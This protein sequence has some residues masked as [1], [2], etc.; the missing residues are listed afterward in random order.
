MQATCAR[1][2]RRRATRLGLGHESLEKRLMLT[3]TP[4]TVVDVSVSST[5]WNS[6]FVDH[7]VLEGLGDNGYSIPTGSSAQEQPIAWNN[8]DQILI[9]FSEDVHVDAADLSLSSTSAASYAFSDF[10]YNPQERV[11]TWTLASPLDS[12]RYHLQLDADGLD[13]VTNLNGDVLDGE[14][15]NMV[16]AGPSGN[17]MA[18]GDFDF[19]FNVLE[20]DALGIGILEYNDFFAVYGRDGQTI[21]DSLYMASAD[22]DGSGNIDQADWQVI[23]DDFFGTLPTATPI[24]ATND[25]PTT[26]GFDLVQITDPNTTASLSL[27]AAFDDQ[28]TADVDLAFAIVDNSDPSLFDSITVDSQTGSLV[29]DAASGVSGRALVTIAATDLSGQTVESTL[30]VDVAYTNSIPTLTATV[31]DG[32]FGFWR[33]E[34]NVTDDDDDL[35]SLYVNIFGVYVDARAYV[36]D[37]GYFVYTV[38]LEPGQID[39]LQLYAT[40]G[41]DSSLS[42]FVEIG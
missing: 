17:G 36:G 24:G 14:W 32:G 6:A 39:F 30:T 31:T 1:G 15:T 27:F 23:I 10:D 20:G 13:P 12:N 26:T 16:T 5:A 37:T 35:D 19:A 22:I 42:V 11:G 41:K 21:G 3:G 2:L 33:I 29:V 8:L 28:E 25:S 34:G 7:L 9:K 38:L 4:P 40:D 18:G